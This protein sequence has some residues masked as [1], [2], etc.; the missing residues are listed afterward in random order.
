MH[1]RGAV[2]L[3]WLLLSPAQSG[4]TGCSAE[5]VRDVTTQQSG[6]TMH[7]SLIWNNSIADS[8]NKTGPPSQAGDSQP[9]KGSD[10]GLNPADTWKHR[11]GWLTCSR[12]HLLCVWGYVCVCVCC[13]NAMHLPV[14]P[15]CVSPR[16]RKTKLCCPTRGCVTGKNVLSV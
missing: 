9:D 7:Q 13:F 15:G 12:P 10:L 3:L 16:W 11:Y 8:W 5:C 6:R 4:Q 2:L 14:K 1:S